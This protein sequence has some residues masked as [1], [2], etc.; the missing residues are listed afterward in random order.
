MSNKKVPKTTCLGYFSE[1]LVRVLRF[2]LKAS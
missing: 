1:L 2:E